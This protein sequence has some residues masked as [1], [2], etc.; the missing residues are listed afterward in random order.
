MTSPFPQESREIYSRLVA[1]EKL[2]NPK[3]K[4]YQAALSVMRWAENVPYG[5]EDNLLTGNYAPWPHELH[6]G[7]ITGYNCTT[8][9]PEIYLVSEEYGLKPE[10]VQFIHCKNKK[11]DEKEYFFIDTGDDLKGG[12]MKKIMP[13]HV[14]VNYI[15]VP[16]VDEYA[17]KCQSLGGK[18]VMG[19]TAVPTMGYFV[20]CLDPSGNCIGLWEADNRAC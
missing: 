8:I 18:V 15:L 3:R 16:N 13:E 2:H 6:S 4:P 19:K 7:K 10:I 20:V 1:A 14:P 9:I 17:N 12:L 11:K 5:F